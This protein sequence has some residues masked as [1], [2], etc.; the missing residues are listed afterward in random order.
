MSQQ[1][2]FFFYLFLISIFFAFLKISSFLFYGLVFNIL[3]LLVLCFYEIPEHTKKWISVS[4]S[5]SCTFFEFFPSAVYF[6]LFLC[7]CFILFYFYPFKV[8]LF[9]NER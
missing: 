8:C 4:L 2:I 3:Q 7:V 1:E 5:V 9:T 6:V